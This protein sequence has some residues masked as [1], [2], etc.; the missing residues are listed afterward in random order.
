MITTG[1]SGKHFEY[2]CSWVKLEG[3]KKNQSY[4][5]TSEGCST[6]RNKLKAVSAIKQ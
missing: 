1:I 3:A 4:T 5:V 2:L 6:L